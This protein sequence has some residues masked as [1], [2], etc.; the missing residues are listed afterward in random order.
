MDNERNDGH[1][2]KKT[3]MDNLLGLESAQREPTSTKMRRRAVTVY[4]A[5]AGN[6]T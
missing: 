6:Y 2:T 1:L 5:V 4:D 3:K